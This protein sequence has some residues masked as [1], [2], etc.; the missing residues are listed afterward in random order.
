MEKMIEGG[1]DDVQI[2]SGHQ[3]RKKKDLDF[4][5]REKSF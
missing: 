5:R 4:E 2:A 1:K 3:P